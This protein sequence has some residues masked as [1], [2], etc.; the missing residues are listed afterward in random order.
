MN[1]N[2]QKLQDQYLSDFNAYLQQQ[3]SK[4]VV[5][6]E[7]Q[8]GMLYSLNAGGKRLRP[9]LFLATLSSL[10]PRRDLT[11]YF[12]IAGALE[13]VHTYSLI[14]DDLP[15][16]DND[17]YRRGKLTNHRQFTVGRAVLAG[18]A[19]LTQAFLWLTDNN[20]TSAIQTSLVKILAEKAGAQGMVA[21]QMTDIVH[22]GEQLS[23]VQ[24]Q[25]LD[26]QKTGALI[27]AAV[28][29]GAVCAQA[30]VNIQRHLINFAQKFGLAFQI[31][32]DLLDLTSD[33][34]TMGK[35]VGKDIAAGKNTY[36][37]LLGLTQARDQLRSL[38]QAAHAELTAI[39]LQN[40]VLDSTLT[41]F[42]LKESNG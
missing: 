4:E 23:L 33:S 29:M 18:D 2:F 40:S 32:D 10:C 21:G 26:R 34:Q 30:D 8:E 16:M 7:L 6:P 42:E 15:E 20:L 14:H 27:T 22:T 9:L 25:Q 28:Q 39:D 12:R 11:S 36:P 24:I 13:L 5:N 41:Y 1:E 31:F 37:K 38:V 19:L 17:D 3:L 35:A